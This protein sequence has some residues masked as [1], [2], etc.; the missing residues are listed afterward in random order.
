MSNSYN[1]FI[2]KG[3]RFG[4]IKTV[5]MMEKDEDKYVDEK[6]HL[7]EGLLREL[8]YSIAKFMVENPEQVFLIEVDNIGWSPSVDVRMDSMRDEMKTT[9]DIYPVDYGDKYKILEA[10]HKE[11]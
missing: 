5:Y 8:G 4:N 1:E 9:M 11:E 2:E 3:E 7:K 6:E 10:L